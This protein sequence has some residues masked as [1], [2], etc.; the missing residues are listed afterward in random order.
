M[1]RGLDHLLAEFSARP[2]TKVQRFQHAVCKVCWR[3][4]FEARRVET[5]QLFCKPPAWVRQR[6]RIQFTTTSSLQTL[7]GIRGCYIVLLETLWAQLEQL[8]LVRLKLK[9][10]ESLPL[11]IH[12]LAVLSVRCFLLGIL[13]GVLFY[14]HFYLLLMSTYSRNICKPQCSQEMAFFSFQ[15]NDDG[16]RLCPGFT[17]K[18]DVYYALFLFSKTQVSMEESQEYALACSPRGPL[19][20]LQKGFSSV[21][22]QHYPPVMDISATF[23][24]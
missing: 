18:L 10:K 11:Q 4:L 22:H 15:A 20:S 1:I 17:D 23:Y 19:A 3:I 13:T 8:I 12:L 21:L 5:C 9:E 6:P 2:A 16:R 14:W 24:P 7:P